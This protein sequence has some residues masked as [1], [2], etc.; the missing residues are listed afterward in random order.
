MRKG[1]RLTSRERKALS[2]A[3]QAA[4]ASALR[5]GGRPRGAPGPARKMTAPH[6]AYCNP[7]MVAGI[8]S[9]ASPGYGRGVKCTLTGDVIFRKRRLNSAAIAADAS[10]GQSFELCSSQ[11]LLALRQA[12]L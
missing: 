9:W 12:S 2:M 3:M 5:Y 10:R 6:P 4:N 7:L 1:S 11:N 8:V